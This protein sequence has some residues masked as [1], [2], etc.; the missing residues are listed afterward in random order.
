M[1]TAWVFPQRDKKD[2][3]VA[4]PGQVVPAEPGDRPRSDLDKEIRGIATSIA[5][6]E[7]R[8][9]ITGDVLR[10]VFFNICDTPGFSA[11]LWNARMGSRPGAR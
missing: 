3:R 5:A 8:H 10:I 7:F 2:I 6:A 11:L 4:Q 1:G 9:R